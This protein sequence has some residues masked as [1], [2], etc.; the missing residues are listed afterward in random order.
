MPHDRA[1]KSC[2][3]MVT[4]T[5]PTRD[6]LLMS[7][8]LFSGDAATWLFVCELLEMNCWF[9][10]EAAESRCRRQIPARLCVISEKGWERMERSRESKQKGNKVSNW[11]SGAL[12]KDF[13]ACG[14]V[15]NGISRQMVKSNVE[16]ALFHFSRNCNSVC[17]FYTF[18]KYVDFLI[19]R[20]QTV[21]QASDI[22]S[23]LLAL[24]K[25]R[26]CGYFCSDQ[27]HEKN[28]NNEF[29]MVITTSISHNDIISFLCATESLS[30]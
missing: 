22:F 16:L 26:D 29:I 24:A 17:Y 2:I 11:G 8:L 10:G 4:A 5:H 27:S 15:S 9:V 12:P 6:T 14:L 13:L 28:T 18:L 21:K 30:K 25:S 1:A 20:I 23:A 3:T 7:S 19:P